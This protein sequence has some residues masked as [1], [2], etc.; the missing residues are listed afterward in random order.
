VPNAVSVSAEISD[1][2][3]QP[4]ERAFAV[5]N[6]VITEELPEPRR[7][8]LRVSQELQLAVKTELVQTVGR[9]EGRRQIFP[10]R[11]GPARLHWKEV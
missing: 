6:P 1:G 8:R 5:D 11:P 9:A 2:V 7:E 4:A 10:K 3:L